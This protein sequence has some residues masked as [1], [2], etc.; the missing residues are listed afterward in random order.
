MNKTY[1]GDRT[2][3]GIQVTVDGEPLP[4]RTDLKQISREGFEWSYEGDA[5]AQLA[6]AILADHAG[7][8]KALAFYESFMETV[9]ANFSNEWEMTSRD[10]DEALEGLNGLTPA[11]AVT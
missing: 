4:E 1:R 7:D 8:E 3:D 2:I 11:A 10:I 6:L 5:P 9:V